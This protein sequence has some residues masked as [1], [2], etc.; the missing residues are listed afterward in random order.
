MLKNILI[1]VAGAVVGAGSTYFILKDK[2]EERLEVDLDDMRGYFEKKAQDKDPEYEEK[3]EL[4]KKSLEKPDISTYKAVLEK[5]RY[6]Q[7]NK[8]SKP[9]PADEEH[10]TEPN[11]D[12]YVISPEEFGVNR[13][14]DTTSLTYYAGDEVLADD[15]D[16]VLDIQT[17][18]GH[19]ALERF[20]EYEDD[21]VYVQNDRF[22]T[23]YEVF[24][25]QRCFHDL[26]DEDID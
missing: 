3:A 13:A 26:S 22:G 16:E 18:I 2:F 15:R 10:P 23:Y 20:G 1:F 6:D 5:V 4:A 14:Y 12:P 17:Y 19:D 9:D 7:V 25:D 11:P 8:E 21:V 24:L